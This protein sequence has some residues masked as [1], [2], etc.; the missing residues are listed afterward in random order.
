L[1]AAAVRRNETEANFQLLSS[2]EKMYVV[3]YAVSRW[4]MLWKPKA[5][6]LEKEKKT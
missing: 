5:K 2:S 4:L 6:C 3:Y 1:V